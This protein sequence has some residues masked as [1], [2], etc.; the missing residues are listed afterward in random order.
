MRV[1]RR[2]RMW[3]STRGCSSQLPNPQSATFWTDNR[4]P[5]GSSTTFSSN[6]PKIK[7]NPRIITQK[8]VNFR[9]GIIKG[10]QRTY[11]RNWNRIKRIGDFGS[12]V[13]IGEFKEGNRDGDNWNWPQL[14]KEE[15]VGGG[16]Q[17]YGEESVNETVCQ[18]GKGLILKEPTHCLSEPI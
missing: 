13:L 9:G 4:T 10:T 15:T 11:V 12:R 8:R 1:L 2:N 7:R 5:I 17:L 14:R 3:S 16:W 6:Y 18:L